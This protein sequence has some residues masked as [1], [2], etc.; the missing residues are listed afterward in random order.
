MLLMLER[1]ANPGERF[2]YKL[3]STTDTLTFQKEVTG[4]AQQGFRAVARTFINKPHV[5]SVTEIAVVMERPV[6]PTKRYEYLLIATN[7]TSTLEKEWTIATSRGY[8]ALGMLTRA[9][10][11]VLMERESKA[12]K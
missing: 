6:N 11:M 10:V 5:M 2:Q 9:E 8:T 12:E 7:L 3:I 1:G 4:A